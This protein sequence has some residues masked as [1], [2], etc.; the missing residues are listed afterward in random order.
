MRKLAAI[1]LALAVTACGGGG[2]DVKPTKATAPAWVPKV[3]QGHSIEVELVDGLDYDTIYDIAQSIQERANRE[4]GTLVAKPVQSVKT[5]SSKSIVCVELDA[6]I[7]AVDATIVIAHI[8]TT[9]FVK[10]VRTN[11]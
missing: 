1:A 11:V 10:A 7:G 4:N 2:E 6:G 5:N 9:R 8:N 3:C